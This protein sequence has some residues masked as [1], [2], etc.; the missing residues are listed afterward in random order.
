MEDRKRGGYR[1]RSVGDKKT[2]AKAPRAPW[3]DLSF[4]K[5]VGY[6]A[7]KARQLWG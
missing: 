4:P 2:E 1:D 6:S 5:P 3:A 7:K